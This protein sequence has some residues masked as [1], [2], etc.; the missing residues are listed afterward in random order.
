M[1]K[2]KSSGSP[3]AKMSKANAAAESYS[4]MMG[5]PQDPNNHPASNMPGMDTQSPGLMTPGQGM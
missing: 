1:K 3:K 2:K 5:T 4:H